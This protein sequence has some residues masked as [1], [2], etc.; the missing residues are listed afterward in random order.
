[1]RIREKLAWIVAAVLGLFIVASIATEVAG[2]PLDPPGTP[3]STMRTL[4]DVLPSWNRAL[5][6]TGGCTSQR[7]QCTFHDAAALDRETGL[8]WQ[9]DSAP[10][11]DG[12][13]W[14]DALAYCR[15]AIIGGKAGWRVPTI[16]EWFTLTDGAL[17]PPEPPF[18]ATANPRYWSASTDPADTANAL[19]W[20][21]VAASVIPGAKSTVP[22]SAIGVWCVRGPGGIDGM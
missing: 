6:S 1:M 2:G 13:T 8:L 20:S 9:L 4:D 11:P 16:E 3:A 7:F 22:A 10:N 21:L 17:Q 15:T 5:S 18:P 19:Y 12:V 14:F